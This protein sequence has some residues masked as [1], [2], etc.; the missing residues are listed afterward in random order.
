MSGAASAWGRHQRALD[1]AGGD[2]VP[3]L[4][5]ALLQQ[6]DKIEIDLSVALFANDEALAA[7]DTTQLS[8]NRQHDGLPGLIPQTYRRAKRTRERAGSNCN[9]DQICR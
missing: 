3:L 6:S 1:A 7:P 9:L 4:E 5:L 2:L 8:G